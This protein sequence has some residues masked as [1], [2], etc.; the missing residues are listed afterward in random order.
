MPLHLM[1]L[2]IQR[3]QQK[4]W[5]IIP[6]KKEA[7]DRSISVNFLC[8]IC[9]IRVL[10]SKLFIYLDCQWSGQEIMTGS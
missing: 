7:G 4:H 8:L 6:P 5:L 9:I 10:L 3:S 2:L 1:H